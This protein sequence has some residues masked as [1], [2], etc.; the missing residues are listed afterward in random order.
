MDIKF[1]SGT[2]QD[3]DLLSLHCCQTISR[4]KSKFIKT[5]RACSAT[6]VTAAPWDHVR[7]ILSS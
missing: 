2:A 1:I 4:L 5:Y 3:S 6:T 7:F